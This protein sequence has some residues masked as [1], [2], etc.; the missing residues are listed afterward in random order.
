M[1]CISS[2]NRGWCDYYKYDTDLQYIDIQDIPY[3]DYTIKF[4]INQTKMQYIIGEPE[5]FPVTIAE[6]DKRTQTRC[7]DII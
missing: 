4:S 3:G 2:R 6:E 5:T 1:P 7:E